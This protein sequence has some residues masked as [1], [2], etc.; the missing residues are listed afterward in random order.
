MY[1][2]GIEDSNKRI[3]EVKLKIEE[4][5]DKLIDYDKFAKM[6]EFPDET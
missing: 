4:F 2:T 5:K 1:K 3:I 6:F